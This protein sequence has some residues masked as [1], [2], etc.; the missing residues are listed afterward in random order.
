MFQ[1]GKAAKNPFSVL[2]S[3]ERP[4][5]FGIQFTDHAALRPNTFHVDIQ[6]KT[7]DIQIRRKSSLLRAQAQLLM[8]HRTAW[9]TY[10]SGRFKIFGSSVKASSSMACFVACVGWPVLIVD[11][12]T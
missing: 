5:D 1:A 9:R 8:A 4:A 11:A 2:Q 3:C 12:V 6:S 7:P 10:P